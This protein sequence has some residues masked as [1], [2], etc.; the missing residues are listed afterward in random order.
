T[1]A[2]NG[3]SSSLL[4]YEYSDINNA[5]GISQYRLRQID[6]NGKQ[7]YSPVRAVRAGGQK[8]KTIIYPNP[9]ND[10]KVNVV[11]ADVN[12]IRDVSLMDM[13]GRVMKQWKGV[14]NNNILIDNL[15]AGF[16]TIRIIETETGEQTVEKIVVKKR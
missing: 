2:M 16:Y 7:A 3:N 15:T 5:K 1:K 8:G 4:N 12:T 14:A 6:I 11:F 9:S 10:G 13:N